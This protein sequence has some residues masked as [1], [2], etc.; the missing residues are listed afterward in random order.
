MKLKDI[1]KKIDS[2][3]E[4]VNM[5]I[6]MSGETA[7]DVA[8]LMKMVK[9]AGGK[10]EIIPPMGPTM[11]PR[12]DIEKSLKVMDLPPMPKKMPMDMEPGCEDEVAKEGEWDNAPDEKY[13]DTAYMQNDLAGGLNRQKK[14]YPKVAGGD[15]P[16]ALEDEI[17]SE[18]RQRLDQMMTSEG[19]VKDEAIKLQ[20]EIRE[21]AQEIKDGKHSFDAINDELNDMYDRVKECGDK[22]CIN[23]FKALRSIEAGDE[24]VDSKAQD[25]IDVVDGGDEGDYPHMGKSGLD[26][27]KKSKDGI[28]H[29]E[30]KFDEAGCKK[31]MKKLNAS[32]CTKEEMKKK[33][34]AEYGCDGK[35]FEKL[36]AAH[37]G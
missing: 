13:Q 30:K 36:Y 21:F 25:A 37:C 8:T 4:A 10:P 14:S 26:E 11:S 31:K 3:N 7:D 12:D 5:S 24:D 2:L 23:A 9:D 33:I 28:L 20:D 17:K 15:N 35:K 29:S 22:V 27:G 34:T 32:G 1:Y 18:L 16:M 6:S 19:G